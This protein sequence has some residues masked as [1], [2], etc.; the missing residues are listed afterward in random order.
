MSQHL[1]RHQGTSQTEIE[2]GR[3]APRRERLSSRYQREAE[4]SNLVAFPCCHD[5]RRI[6]VNRQSAQRSR[7][8]K[9]QY[10]SELE[11]SVTS[12]QTEVSALSPRVAFLDHQRSLLTLASSS[13]SPRSRR[14]RSSKMLTAI[15]APPRPPDSNTSPVT[16]GIQF[17]AACMQNCHDDGVPNLSL[18]VS[19][20]V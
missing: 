20:P 12:L 19:D 15:A 10:M 17:S 9:L 13:G 7:V 16:I 5:Y 11:R 18:Q 14:T 3:A 2:P 8:R 4:F 1:V 6:L